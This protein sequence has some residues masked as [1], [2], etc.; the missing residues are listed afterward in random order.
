MKMY[1]VEED[2]YIQI[3]VPNPVLRLFRVQGQGSDWIP[4]YL[5]QTLPSAWKCPGSHRS[6]AK[7]IEVEYGRTILGK[8]R[9]SLVVTRM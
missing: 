5:G 7:Q 2:Y 4:S 1:E 3:K 6:E 9:Y 8:A